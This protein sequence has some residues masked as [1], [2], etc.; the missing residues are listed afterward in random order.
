MGTTNKIRQAAFKERMREIGKRQVTIWVDQLKEQQVKALLAS[1]GLPVTG[2]NELIAERDMLAQRV[3]ALEARIAAD[4]VEF[5]T[6]KHKRQMMERE[7]EDLK[8]EADTWKYKKSQRIEELLGK[9]F[10]MPKRD[11]AA[12]FLAD[13]L[14]K[15]IEKGFQFENAV[16]EALEFGRKAAVAASGIDE[17]SGRLNRKGQLLPVE[18]AI[19]GAAC[20][21]LGDV[22]LR[23][24]QIKESAKRSA[25][26]I[27]REEE[28]R[29]K[30]AKVA[31]AA[32]FPDLKNMD[33]LLLVSYQFNLVGWG[34]FSRRALLVMRPET[35]NKRDIGYEIEELTNHVRRNLQSLVEAAIVAG[36]PATEAAMGLRSSF[37]MARGG[38]ENKY[39]GQIAHIRACQVAAVLS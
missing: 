18:K 17:V 7:I 19:L 8:C 5:D 20:T 10:M 31:V 4:R 32:A 3:V 30:A 13:Y 22:H 6:A 16:K 35:A 11:L 27:K 15:P 36:T 38:L 26:R 29:A 2:M 12:V 14:G 23:A 25:E 1:D 39:R 24:T 28:A 9:R 34:D 37:D 21:I 33:V